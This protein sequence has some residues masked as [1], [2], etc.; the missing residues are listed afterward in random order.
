[1]PGGTMRLGPAFS[2]TLLALLASFASSAAWATD[3]PKVEA[4]KS[5]DLVILSTVDVRGSFL[6]CGCTIPKGGLPRRA[7]LIDSTRGLRHRVLVVD[8]GAVF[9]DKP[10]RRDVGSFIME[11]MA[12]M[13]TDAAGVGDCDLVNGL[14][15]LRS[16]ALETG[17]PLTCANLI[18][19]AT[20]QPA[21]QPWRLVHAGDVKVG[22]FG[23]LAQDAARGPAA[24]SLTLTDPVLSAREA[25]GQLRAHGA[26][27]IVLLSQLGD[28]PTERLLEDV[29]GIDV[30][31]S[32]GHAMRSIGHMTGTTFVA[33][34]GGDH[35]Y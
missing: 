14:D 1:H 9:P 30:A 15:F 16:T 6:P 18:E 32:N 7:A 17:V 2:S 22:G 10:E 23:L 35:G 11:C 28:Q 8:A 33:A 26:T 29:T 3:A 19:S 27:V 21:F 5:D 25:I 31:I 4:A 24:G 12:A 13:K 20:G 34:G